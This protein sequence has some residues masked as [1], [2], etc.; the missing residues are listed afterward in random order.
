MSDLV[1][2]KHR[3]E[4]VKHNT[5]SPYRDQLSLNDPNSNSNICSNACVLIDFLQVS[6]LCLTLTFRF[7]GIS[8]LFTIFSSFVFS[9]VVVNLAGGDLTGLK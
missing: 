6:D 9:V 5:K 3:K 4:D 2:Y 7:V 1:I 8:C